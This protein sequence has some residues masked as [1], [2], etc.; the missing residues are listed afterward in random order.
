MLGVYFGGP[1]VNLDATYLNLENKGGLYDEIDVVQMLPSV[2]RFSFSLL[3]SVPV[4]RQEHRC[5]RC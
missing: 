3:T 5:F 1:P 2:F 4:L